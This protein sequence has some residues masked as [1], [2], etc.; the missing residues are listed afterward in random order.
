MTGMSVVG[1]LFGAG[2]MFLPQVVKSARVM[3]QAVAYLMPYMEK[4]KEEMGLAQGEPAGR[5]LLATVKG[6]VHDIGKNIVGVVLQCNNYQVT[7]LGVMVPAQKIL[8]KARELKVDIIG[9]SG[10]ITPSLDEMCHVAAEMEREGFDLPLLIGGAT[11]SRIHTAVKISPNYKRSQAV[12]VTDASRAVGVVSSL[13][14]P[15]ERPKVIAQVREDYLRMAET[16][17]RGRAEKSRVSLA[18][19]R[20]NR[21]NIDW[22]GYTPP[23]PSFLGTRSF[24][25]YDLADLARYIDWSPFFQAW[26]LKGAYPRILED[27]KYGE[28]AR[29]L[30]DDAQ[31]LLKQLIAEEWLV[32][33]GVVGFWPA[34]SVG[35]DI[36]IYSDE[37][38]KKKIAT[39]H[40]LRQQM[41]R[42]ESKSNLALSDFIAPKETGLAD[43]IGGF[44]VTTGI[45]E[46]DVARRFERA[47]DDYSKI[48]VKALADRLAEAFAEAMHEKVRR[49]LWA[50]APTEKLSNQELI[51]ETYSGIRPAPGYP[52]QPDHTEK[53]TLFELLDAEKA[54]GVKLTESYAMWPAAAV[55]GLYF[56]HP[57]SR[58][59]GLGKIGRDQVEDYA[60]RKGWTVVEAERWLAP[61]LNYDTKRVAEEAA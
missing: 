57:E 12:Y 10:L 45:G 39:L 3:K 41:L 17:A 52:A 21:M 43:Y 44:A 28:A 25:A 32:A 15:E 26:E 38:R 30:F 61:V 6:D 40:T 48:M 20:A 13:M 2:K 19:A 46:E 8:D 53:G 18:Q 16:H 33:N 1:D 54:A 58:Y 23:K 31:A 51:A 27:D 11:T 9:L 55:S 34:N 14:S 36:E 56:S 4:E 7:D 24:K 50:Y 49:E 60:K 37:S 59:F 29:N 47:N 22:S 35:D 42:D 5:I